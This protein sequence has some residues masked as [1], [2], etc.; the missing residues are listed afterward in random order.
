MSILGFDINK[1]FWLNFSNGFRFI[2][3]RCIKFSVSLCIF[4]CSDLGDSLL[5]LSDEVCVK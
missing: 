5:Y 2:S 4:R 3:H 1:E